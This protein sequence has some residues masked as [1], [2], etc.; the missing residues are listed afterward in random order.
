MTR[1]SFL[2]AMEGLKAMTVAST[3]VG[4]G[5]SHSHREIASIVLP[6]TNPSSAL[7]GIKIAKSVVRIIF[8]NVPGL[9]VP[10]PKS[11]VPKAREIRMAPE[12]ANLDLGNMIVLIRI[13]WSQMTLTC[14]TDKVSKMTI[15]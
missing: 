14:M 4:A 7:S 10:I 2:F 12:R 15:Y 9:V 1:C 3:K 5:L 11:W 13:S 8:P 6:A